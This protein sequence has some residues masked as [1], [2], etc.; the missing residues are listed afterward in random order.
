MTKTVIKT[1]KINVRID[2]HTKAQAEKL[3]SDMGLDISTAV[4][5]FIRQSINCGGIPFEVRSKMPNKE[6]IEAM[7]EAEEILQEKSGRVKTAEDMFDSL[8]I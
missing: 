2:P 3:F 4:N 7:K 5:I 8:G 1:S 6:T